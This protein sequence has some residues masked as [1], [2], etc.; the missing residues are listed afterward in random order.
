MANT[1]QLITGET[2][3]STTGSYT[4]SSIPS[5]YTDLMV[6]IS[7]RTD[8]ADTYQSGGM[9][10]N[11][12]AA[13]NSY[14]SLRGNGASATSGNGSAQ[15][16]WYCGEWNGAN[17]TSNTFTSSAI[18]IPNYTSSNQKSF[19][20]DTVQENN[21]TTAIA[22]MMAG[23]CTKTAAISSITFRTFGGGGNSFVSGSSFYLY[24][25]KNS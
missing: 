19:T 12:V 9:Y 1:Y 22:M 23:L 8:V 18:Y 3:A 14:R 24:G 11:S 21:G 2:L 17:S 15:N 20:A 16:E 7:V 10:V 13:D 25:I 6:L 5:T 4:F